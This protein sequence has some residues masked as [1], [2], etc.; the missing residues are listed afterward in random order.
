MEYLQLESI[1]SAIA[2]GTVCALIARYFI[3]KAFEDLQKIKEHIFEIGAKLSIIEVKLGRLDKIEEKS[4]SHDSKITEIQ[5]RL[6]YERPERR[7]CNDNRPSE[8]RV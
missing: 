6:M 2:G 3:L 1:G 7:P 5:S 8:T 4:S